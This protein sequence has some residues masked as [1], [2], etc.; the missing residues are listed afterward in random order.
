MN[1]INIEGRKIGPHHPP[2]IIAEMSGNHNQSLERAFNIIEEAAKAGAHALKIQ[3]YTAD[4]MTLNMNS[5]DFKIED[6]N[7]LWSGRTLYTLYQQAYTPWEWHKPIFDKCRELGMIPL[8]T[9]FDESSVDF[10]EDLG[11]PIYKIASFENTD[12]PLIKKVAATGKPIIISTGMATVAEIDESIRAAKEAGCKELI[13]LKCTSTYPAS[14]ENTNIS[15]IPHMKELFNCQVGL[16]D[17]T[18]GTGVAVASV[19]L[20]ATVIEKHF[21]L[22]RADGG[23]DSAFSLEPSE[24]KELVVETG[25]AWQAL[26]QI[27][28]GPTD[29]EKASLKF[30]RSIYVKKDIKAGEIFTKDNIKV[31][32]PGY[33]LEP[34][35][36][37]VIIGRTAKKHIAAGTPLK[38]D[39]I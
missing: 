4:T 23:V 16:S 34:K 36:Y 22:S 21:T 30:R 29:E 7:S 28:Y 24:L 11:V 5:K 37:D 32:R 20:G 19:A 39:S 35:F 3:T 10:L 13:L 14:P 18:M 17:H 33:G 25:R 9:P 26:G 12:I 8:S 2:F 31:V 15:T 6:E 1:E 38:W 27:T